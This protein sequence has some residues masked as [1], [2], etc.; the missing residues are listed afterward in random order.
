MTLRSDETWHRLRAWTYG[1]TPSERLAAQVLLDAGYVDIDPIH[2]RGGPD[3]GKDAFATRDGV[4]W[5]MAVYFPHDAQTYAAIKAKAVSDAAGV[6]K[7]GAHGMAFVTNQE[8]T[9]SERAALQ[10]KLGVPL[11]LFHI[12]RLVAALDKPAMHG[13]R[14]QYL[15]ID[16][17]SN[18]QERLS[19]PEGELLESA[20]RASGV[21]RMQ[22]LRA[23]GVAEERR[24]QVETW[25]RAHQR[26]PLVIPPGRSVL[27]LS[28]PMGYGKIELAH[29]WLEDC[30]HNAIRSP[31]APFPLWVHARDITGSLDAHVSGQLGRAI[32]REIGCALVIDGLDELAPA[33][34]V[35][36]LESAEEF[37]GAWPKS[38]ANTPACAQMFGSCHLQAECPSI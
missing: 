1:Q 21:R 33:T 6:A 22:R 30:I 3:G 19:P 13:V 26:Q 12:E 32:V 2:P 34:A 18:G 37:C 29:E 7:N 28:A 14:R 8:L 10:K 4:R 17:G 35:R 9:L 5:I 31:D 20:L 38:S 27:L 16:Y 25:M 11:D 36:L 15:N 24:P 23:A